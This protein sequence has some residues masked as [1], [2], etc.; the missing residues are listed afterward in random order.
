MMVNYQSETLKFKLFISQVP[1]PYS[2]SM[3]YYLFQGLSINGF[4]N[5]V[6]TSIER[7]F[8]LNSTQTGTIASTYDIGSMI[9]MI[10]VCFLGGKIGSSKPRSDTVV[11]DK[12]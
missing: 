7:R 9:I 11:P 4:V 3:P 5:V 2:K 8:G 12:I 10:P 6:I 1:I